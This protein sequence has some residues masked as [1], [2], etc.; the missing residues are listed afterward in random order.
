[1]RMLFIAAAATLTLAAC[2]KPAEEAP[3]V[4]EPAA[5]AGMDTSATAPSGSGGTMAPSYDTAPDTTA[6][7]PAEGSMSTGPSEATRDTAKEQAETTNL[8]P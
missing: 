4:A 7:A 3:P 6:V 8:H 2:S 5:D 1:M